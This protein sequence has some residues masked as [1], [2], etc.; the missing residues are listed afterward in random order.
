MEM[1]LYLVKEKKLARQGSNK[2]C[3]SSTDLIPVLHPKEQI[4]E[5]DKPVGMCHHE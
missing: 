5:M 2:C 1:R 4:S 3:T